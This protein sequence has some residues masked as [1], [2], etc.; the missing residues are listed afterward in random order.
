MRSRNGKEW[1][2]V[3]VEMDARS[4][5]AKAREVKKE[6]YETR[7]TKEVKNTKKVVRVKRE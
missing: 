7:Q 5:D 1:T 4:D 2:G 6:A 3:V